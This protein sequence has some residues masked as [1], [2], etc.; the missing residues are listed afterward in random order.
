MLEKRTIKNRSK[1]IGTFHGV[2]AYSNRK[3][4]TKNHAPVI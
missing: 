4:G 1:K 3:N 2:P